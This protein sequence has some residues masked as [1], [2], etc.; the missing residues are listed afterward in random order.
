MKASLS[1]LPQVIVCLNEDKFNQL[2]AD[3]PRGPFESEKGRVGGKKKHSTLKKKFHLPRSQNIP[4]H[5]PCPT[6]GPVS[7]TPATPRFDMT[8]PSALVLHSSRAFISICVTRQHPF[9]FF[10]PCARWARSQPCAQA[11]DLAC[12]PMLSSTKKMYL[13]DLRSRSKMFVRDFRH[14]GP[15]STSKHFVTFFFEGILIFLPK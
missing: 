1:R 5:F 6:W 4:L 9:C 14:H 10:F 7:Q 11:S 12:K 8:Y 2:P 3:S 13:L 15:R